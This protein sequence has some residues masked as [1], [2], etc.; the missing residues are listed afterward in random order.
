MS[1]TGRTLTWARRARI[2]HSA[3]RAT[4]DHRRGVAAVTAGCTT[5]HP[6]SVMSERVLAKGLRAGMLLKQLPPTV[7]VLPSRI[8]LG[9]R[10]LHVLLV[11]A[12]ID[13]MLAGGQ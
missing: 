7:P 9:G 13:R 1:W 3:M 5:H 11:V 4:Y 10:E 2:L 12:R 6:P 8:V